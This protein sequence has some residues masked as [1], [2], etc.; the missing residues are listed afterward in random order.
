MINLSPFQRARQLAISRLRLQA[1]HRLLIV[2]IGTGADL[3]HLPPGVE[4]VGIDLSPAMLKVAARKLLECDS[5]V[6]LVIADAARLPFPSKCFDAVL[7]S[8]IL[9][10]VPDASACLEEVTRV[11][12]P[13]CRIVVLDKFLHGETPSLLR[14]LLNVLTRFFGTDINRNLEAMLAGKGM[15][16]VSRVP[17]AFGGT[18]EVIELRHDSCIHD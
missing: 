3:P 17:A 16:V 15:K 18:Y 11:A 10:V 2:G 7:L 12:N 1:G 5:S 9:S 14:R 8:L 6:Q 13:D 4:V